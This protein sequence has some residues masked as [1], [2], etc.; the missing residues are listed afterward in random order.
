MFIFSHYFGDIRAETRNAIVCVVNNI[1]AHVFPLYCRYNILQTFTI[2]RDIQSLD[3]PLLSML[4]L[5]PR[6]FQILPNC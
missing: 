3:N 2:M 6:G 1:L 4:K 5:L